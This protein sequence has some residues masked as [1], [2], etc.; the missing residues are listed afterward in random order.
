MNESQGKKVLKLITEQNLDH[1]RLDKLDGK[2]L[3]LISDL[4]IDSNL[5]GEKALQVAELGGE[6]SQRLSVKKNWT[7]INY[8]KKFHRN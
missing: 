8:Q 4:T 1:D 3:S 5:D 6:R 7:S 2:S